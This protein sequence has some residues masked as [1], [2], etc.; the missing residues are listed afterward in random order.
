M[1]RASAAGYICSSSPVIVISHSAYTLVCVHLS[2]TNTQTQDWCS[3]IW[4]YTY[5]WGKDEVGWAAVSMKHIKTF[6]SKH[7]IFTS[8]VQNLFW[9]SNLFAILLFKGHCNLSNISWVV[10]HM[11]N[12]LSETNITVTWFWYT[13]IGFHVHQWNNLPHQHQFQPAFIDWCWELGA[14]FRRTHLLSRTS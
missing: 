11:K 1:V 4:S 14:F 10:R 5:L 12:V 3:R 8:I 6:S 13:T 2:H 7:L 9:D